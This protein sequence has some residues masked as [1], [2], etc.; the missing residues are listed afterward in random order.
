MRQGIIGLNPR[1]PKRQIL[2]IQRTLGR[3]QY[4]TLGEQLEG[5]LN[6]LMMCRPTIP[7]FVSQIYFKRPHTFSICK[8]R[9]EIQCE[10]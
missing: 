10:I 1:A 8:Q 5:V 3:L 6:V 4:R 2:Q 9:D 7:P